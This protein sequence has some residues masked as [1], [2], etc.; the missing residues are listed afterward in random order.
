MFTPQTTTYT[1][2]MLGVLVAVS[3][4]SSTAAAQHVRLDF[5]S[6]GQAGQP[7]VE[8]SVTLDGNTGALDAIRYHPLVR[9]VI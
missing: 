2:K 4:F 6:Q 3:L 1:H 8:F 7:D 9:Y 5:F